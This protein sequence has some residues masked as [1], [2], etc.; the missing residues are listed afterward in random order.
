M[1]STPQSSPK[2]TVRF[3]LALL[4]VLMLALLA[5]LPAAAVADMRRCT[6]F[7]DLTVGATYLNGDAFVS[8]GLAFD[9]GPFLLL[10]GAPVADGAIQVTGGRS[11]DSGGARLSLANATLTSSFPES[12]TVVAFRFAEID[13]NVN[14]QVN[15]D[16][17]NVANLAD[18]HGVTVG[19]ALVTVATGPGNGDVVTVA[20]AITQ[21]II[22]GHDFDVDDFCVEKRE[23]GD[24][25]GQPGVLTLAKH[26]DAPVTSLVPGAVMTYT[27]RVEHVGGASPATTLVSDTLPAGLTLAGPPQVVVI[28]PTVTPAWAAT[29]GQWVKWRGNLAPNAI[30]ELRIPVRLAFCTGAELQLVN[31]A[32]A[33]QTDQSLLT[34]SVTT[35]AQCPDAPPVSVAK[36]ILLAEGEAVVEV[37]QADILPGMDVAFRLKVSNGGVAPVI[38]LLRDPLPQGLAPANEAAVRL[39]AGVRVPVDA[40]ATVDYDFKARLAGDMAVDRD[41]V[42]VGRF[43]VCLVGANGEPLCPRQESQPPQMTATN[44]VTLTVRGR[45][46]GDAPDNTNHADAP[47][48]AYAG[49][50]ARFPTVADPTAPPDGPVHQT[51]RPFHL[52]VNVSREANADIGADADP[53]NNLL[54][55]LDQANLDR[56]D[57]GLRPGSIVLSDCQT[58]ALPVAIFFDPA[59]AAALPEGKGYLNVWVDGN[60]D[61]DWNDTRACAT[62]QG[63]LAFEHI[64]VD[65][66]VDVT[67]LVTGVNQ[68]TIPATLPA[69]WPPELAQQPAWLRVTLSERPANKTLPAG[70]AAYGDGRGYP[71]PFLFG[72]T[73]DYLLRG[74]QDPANGPDL[75]VRKDGAVAPAQPADPAR[76]H[77]LPYT[78]VVWSIQYANRGDAAATDVRIEDDLALAGDVSRLRIETHPPL[79]YTLD[80]SRVTFAVGALEARRVGHI[81]IK[82]GVPAGQEEGVFT[83]TVTIAAASDS[84][85]ANN[86]AT[87][88]TR[89]ELRPPL[90]VEPGDGTTCENAL[91]VRGRAIPQSEV[92]LYVDDA[93]AGTALTDADGRWALAITLADGEHTLYAMTRHQGHTSAASRVTASTVDSALRW[94]PL[95][96]RFIDSKGHSHRPVDEEGRTDATGWGI[97]LRPQETYTVA[98]KLCCT[99]AGATARLVISDTFAVDL[100]DPDGDQMYTGVFVAAAAPHTAG[101]MVLVV[102]CGEVTSQGGGVVLIDPEGV[103]Y[104]IASQTLLADATVAC[105][106]GQ[107]GDERAAFTLWPAEDYGQVNPQMTAGDGY[108]SFFT[109][110]GIYRLDV[111]RS[112][113]QPYRSIDLAVVDEPVRQD[114]P[115]TPQ[116][117]EADHV[118]AITAEGFDPAYLA[119]KPGE[120]VEWV[121]MAAAGRTAT[122]GDGGQVSF[123]SGLLLPGERYRFV[124]PAAGSYAYADAAG[125][126]AGTLVVARAETA[127]VRVFLPAVQK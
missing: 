51:P 60:R 22:G 13:G 6:G 119:V 45:D 107:A 92:D 8:N 53:T 16:A 43:T 23:G 126:A 26:I 71:L 19:G 11:A 99:V 122:A 15:A 57:D 102:Q 112:G 3:A 103:V 118:I 121:N 4:T 83:N 124:F 95:S 78:H 68:L 1:L 20:G 27:I 40:G 18:L 73:E 38:V 77:G 69:L 88:T 46:L 105:L 70:G 61:G 115:L 72:E 29:N 30:M 65:A 21:L 84:D 5:A 125:D 94:S 52:G 28:S 63:A 110:V 9:V 75:T 114:I 48:T 17:R 98:V 93:L 12:V 39:L 91:T 44:P 2:R 64:V 123:D 14:L 85:P 127:A 41:L 67:T 74:Q 42:N 81:L 109:P 32:T 62:P 33:I 89:F 54:P 47:M 10:D 120:V 106:Q 49:V 86:T 104:D 87:A 97:R 76:E 100:T 111:Q 117:A 66:V 55:L 34:A 35:P 59:V 56:H 90:I 24:G 31:T 25:G 37:E 96:L 58:T 113:Y 108:F 7:E 36:R 80:G 79:S 116:M 82:L 101:S 50:P